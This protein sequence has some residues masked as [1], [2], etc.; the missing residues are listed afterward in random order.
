MKRWIVVAL[1][2][3]LLPWSQPAATREPPAAGCI[4][5]HALDGGWRIGERE[6]VI[7][8]DAQ[9]G[10]R[11]ELDTDCPVLAEGVDL[12]VLA[13]NDWACPGGRMLVRSGSATC[14]VIRMRTLSAPELADALRVQDSP[15]QS[16][17]TLERVQVRGR[18]WREIRGTTDYCVDARFLRGWREDADGL[19]V[20]V[21]PR[22]HAG[23]RYY[24]VETATRCPDLSGVRSIRLLSRNG[25]AAVCGYPGD[26]VVLVDD[27]SGGFSRMG[28]PPTAAYGRGCEIKRVTPFPRE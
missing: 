7:H 12:V 4:D 2:V 9:V 20:E 22:R 11:L 15:A 25:G 24:R 19:V 3:W 10:V 13:P 6:L 18:H 27:A 21:S 26:R 1:G 17:A 16:S 28:G 8:A 14:P 23:H 5:L